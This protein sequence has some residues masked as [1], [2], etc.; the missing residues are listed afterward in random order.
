M[1]HCNEISQQIAASG[2]M[3]LKKVAV[4]LVGFTLLGGFFGRSIYGDL[5]PD[6]TETIVRGFRQSAR[7]R[8][9]GGGVRK[10]GAPRS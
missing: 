6:A 1:L 3:V 9:L 10:F 2:S 8:G 4:G 5:D 7:R